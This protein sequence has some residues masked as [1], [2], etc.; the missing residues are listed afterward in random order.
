MTKGFGPS[1]SLFSLLIFDIVFG[2]KD[3]IDE[4]IEFASCKMKLCDLKLTVRYIISYG[5]FNFKAFLQ[6]YLLKM[7]FKSSNRNVTPFVIA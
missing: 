1:K 7:N 6:Y 3:Y 2:N 5:G 4:T